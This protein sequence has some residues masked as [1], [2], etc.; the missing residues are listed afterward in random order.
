MKTLAQMYE[1]DLIDEK[2]R[3]KKNKELDRYI[4]INI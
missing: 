2:Q 3:R 1:K 4:S